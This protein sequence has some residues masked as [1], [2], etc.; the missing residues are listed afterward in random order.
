MGQT[1]YIDRKGDAGRAHARLLETR[2]GELVIDV[3]MVLDS[4]DVLTLQP[5]QVL[6]VSYRAPDGT[7]CYFDAVA[8]GRGTVGTLSC[9]RISRPRAR[10]ITRVQRR[11]FVRAAV[12][13]EVSLL[14]ISEAREPRLVTGRGTTRD[15]SGGGL[16]FY[17]DRLLLVE[18]GDTVTVK[19]SLPDYKGVLFPL[20]ARA[21]VSRIQA[22]ARGRTVYSV[23]FTE[24][25]DT[26]QQR[27][28]QYVFRIQLRERLSL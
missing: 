14:S 17:P 19:F 27:I 4:P 13:V 9:E 7:L 20:S 8:L 23:R 22:D 18:I 3:P 12:P 25:S 16:S 10:D 28:V 11:A 15:I 5:G 1:V 21:D 2:S 24:V 6:Q 26:V